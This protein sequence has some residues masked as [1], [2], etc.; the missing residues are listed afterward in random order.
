MTVYEINMKAL[1]GE[2]L[3]NKIRF[4]VE[5]L[6]GFRRIDSIGVPLVNIGDYYLLSIDG[7]PGHLELHG[8]QLLR[9]REVAA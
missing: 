6:G 9:V 4:E 3:T 7:L 8:S 5:L 2:W 1:H